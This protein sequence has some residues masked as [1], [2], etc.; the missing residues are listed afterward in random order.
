MGPILPIFSSTSFLHFYRCLYNDDHLVYHQHIHQFFLIVILTLLQTSAPTIPFLPTYILNSK[1]PLYNHTK[2]LTIFQVP[3]NSSFY[4]H[5]FHNPHH[6]HPHPHPHFFHPPPL[7]PIS[8]ISLS[9]THQP[10]TYNL[11]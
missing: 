6:P 1:H 10:Y 5:F 3:N 11:H 9:Q 7:S 8:S 4:S 2:V